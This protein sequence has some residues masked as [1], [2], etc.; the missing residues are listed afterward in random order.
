[1]TLTVYKKA[2]SYEVATATSS[3]DAAGTLALTL[4]LTLY[5]SVAMTALHKKKKESVII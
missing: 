5:S 2:M 4:S 3:L 1:M